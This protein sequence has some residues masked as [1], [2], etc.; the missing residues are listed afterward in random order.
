MVGAHANKSW[1]NIAWHIR[2][3]NIRKKNNPDG[4]QL[5]KK[6][7]IYTDLKIAAENKS[8]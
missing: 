3:K 8:I 4:K 7:S 6:N 5:D 1:Q 2:E